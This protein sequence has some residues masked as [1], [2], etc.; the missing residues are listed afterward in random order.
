MATAVQAAQ[1][2]TAG[3]A[4]AEATQST[5]SLIAK[6]A[7][8]TEGKAATPEPAGMAVEV[9]TAVPEELLF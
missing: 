3:L 4:V 1:E 2:G 6:V 8:G 7:L 5:G 9:V